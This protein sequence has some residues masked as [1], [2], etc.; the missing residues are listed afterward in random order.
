MTLRCPPMGASQE[1]YEAT[2][3]SRQ[4]GAFGLPYFLTS[5]LLPL[6]A[7]CMSWLLED[8]GER[9][10]CGGRGRAE[11]KERDGHDTR[12]THRE[13]GFGERCNTT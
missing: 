7:V 13:Q 1:G 10:R 5:A 3:V 6:T 12:I 2:G 9:E 8:E 11:Q 4:V